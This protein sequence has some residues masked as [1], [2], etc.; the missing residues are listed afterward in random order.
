MFNITT[1]PLKTFLKY[2]EKKLKLSFFSK[3]DFVLFSLKKPNFTKIK[4][5]KPTLILSFY[6]FYSIILIYIRTTRT[7]A[8]THTT[9]LTC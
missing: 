1:I 4:V 9:R 8:R 7:R 2:F 5:G 6:L 3:G